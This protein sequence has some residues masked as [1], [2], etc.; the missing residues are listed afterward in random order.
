MQGTF[1]AASHVKVSHNSL[2]L[3]EEQENISGGCL[4]SI[5]R[6]GKLVWP[7]HMDSVAFLMLSELGNQ[8]VVIWWTQVSRMQLRNAVL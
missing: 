4:T 3:W 6:I 5:P 8:S 1:F 7:D 2:L